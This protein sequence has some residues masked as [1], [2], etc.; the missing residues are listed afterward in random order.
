[1]NVARSNVSPQVDNCPTKCSARTSPIG[2]S[3]QGLRMK[4][5]GESTTLKDF[6]CID[7]ENYTNS[8]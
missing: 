5:R 7:Q 6:V 2:A 3:W 8:A 4:P 1:M